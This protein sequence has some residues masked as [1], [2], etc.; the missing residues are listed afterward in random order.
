MMNLGYSYNASKDYK[1]AKYWYE[2]VIDLD[3]DTDNTLKIISLREAM[4]NLGLL[5][6]LYYVF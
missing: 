5:Y 1:Q 2:K 6:L 3:K 4:Y